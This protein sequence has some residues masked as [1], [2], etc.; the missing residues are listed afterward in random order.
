MTHWQNNLE[1]SLNRVYVISYAESRLST[2]YITCGLWSHGIWL[3]AITAMHHTLHT[4]HHFDVFV[5]LVI[6]VICEIVSQ[7]TGNNKQLLV[8]T[9]CLIISSMQKRA[10]I[11]LET[12][13]THL[14]KDR[15]VEIAIILTDGDQVE[16]E[17]SSF[18]DPEGVT[19]NSFVSQLTGISPAMYRDAP[20]FTDLAET[21]L[22]K[23]QNRVLYAHNARFDYAF[24]KQAFSRMDVAFSSPYICTVRLSKLLYPQFHKHNLDAVR[25][26]FSLPEESRHRALGDTRTLLWFLQHIYATQPVE[27]VEKVLEIITARSTLPPL[28]K[29]DTI[30]KL[31]TTPGV[32]IFKDAQKQ[33]LYVGKSISIKKRVQSHFYNTTS[34]SRE[35]AVFQQMSSIDV[36]ETMTEF[37]ALVEESRLVKILLPVYNRKLR[38]KQTFCLVSLFEDKFGYFNLL[39]DRNKRI[40]PED[41]SGTICIFSSV[42]TAKNAMVYLAEEHGLCQKYL[43]LEKTR[44]ACFGYHLGQCRGA[45]VRKEEPSVHNKMLVDALQPHMLESW[46]FGSSIVAYSKDQTSQRYHVIDHWCYYGSFNTLEEAQQFDIQSVTTP[47]EFDLDHYKIIVSFLKKSDTAVAVL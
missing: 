31:P 19:L 16:E 44:S 41:L 37:E 46:P 38:R 17:W 45:C 36:V 40:S 47:I 12:T 30:E 11:D 32:Y 35:L 23:L 3:V 14:E 7:A 22:T 8:S 27:K 21:I 29:R 25:Q 13:G 39:Y 9:Y 43:G 34:D 5:S 33:V 10:F 4:I 26:R 15:I 1:L 2:W 24:L 28:L 18:V 6:R 42:R 20:R